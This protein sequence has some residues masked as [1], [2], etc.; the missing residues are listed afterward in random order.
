M[1]IM[2]KIKLFILGMTSIMLFKP[3]VSIAQTFNQPGFLVYSRETSTPNLLYFDLIGSVNNFPAPTGRVEVYQ[4]KIC[5]SH[6]NGSYIDNIKIYDFQANLLNTISV[7]VQLTTCLNFIVLPNLNFALLDNVNDKIY[8]LD[9]NGSLQKTINILDSPSPIYQS[10][11]GVVVENSLI[12]SENE[13]K[14]LLKIDLTNYNVSVFKD[15]SHFSGSLGAI[16]YNNGR[17]YF[18]TADADGRKIYSFIDGQAEELVF[19]LPGTGSYITS[20]V[21]FDDF[22]YATFN[23]EFRILKVNIS[24]SDFTVF[25]SAPEGTFY[26]YDIEGINL[27]SF[28]DPTAASVEA[29]EIAITDATLNGIV[30]ANNISTT[31]TFEYWTEN[32]E[33]SSSPATPSPVTGADNTAVSADITGLDAGTIYYFR[34]K[35]E[36]TQGIAYSDVMTFTTYKSDAIHDFDGNYYNIVEIG[37]QVWMSENLKT[38]KYNDGTSIPLVN[39]P[40]AWTNLT[41]PGYCWYNN[42]QATYGNTYGALYNWYTVNAGKLCP[43]GWHLPT[44]LEWTTL[45]T[46]LDESVAAKKLKESGNA[47][48]LSPHHEGTNETGF[49]ALPGGYRN[50]S[51]GVFWGMGYTGFWESST[52]RPGSTS[53]IYGRNM[54]YESTV[55]ISLSEKRDG[56]SVR[57]IKDV[58]AVPTVST[59]P[60]SI[61][62]AVSAFG[63]GDVIS[64]GGATI[65][66]RG[67]CWSIS[68][69]PTTENSKGLALAG[70]GSYTCNLANLDPNTLYYVRAF[71]RNSAGTGYGTQEYFTTSAELSPISFPDLT[72]GTV[73]DVDDNNY[74][75]IQI[76]SQ[77]WMAENLKTT[78]YNDNTSISIV[79]DDNEWY[80]LTTPAYCWYKNDASNYKAIYGALYNWYVGDAASNGGKNVCPVGWRI[81]SNAEWT[82]LTAYLGGTIVAGGK[83]KEVGTSHWWTP[84]EGATNETGFTAIPGGGRIKDGDFYGHFGHIGEIGFWW[85]KETDVKDRMMRYN[86]G[87]VDLFSAFP[88]QCGFSIRCVKNVSEPIVSTA[89]IGIITSISALSGGDVTSDGGGLISARGVCW[90]TDPTPTVDLVTKTSDG[91]GTGIFSS[92]ITGLT[93]G[94]TYYVRAYAT[95]SAGTSYGDVVTLTTTIQVNDVDD[96]TYNTVKIGDQLW[97]KENLEVVHYRNGDAI[98]NVTDLPAWSNLTNGAYC[99]YDNN[100][101]NGDLYGRLYN[102]Y[103]TVDNRNLCPAGWRI[104]AEFDW[105]V[106]ENYL[107][108]NGYNYDGTSTGNKIAKS[109]ASETGWESSSTTGAVGNTDYSAYRNKSGFTGLPGGF[110]Y[111]VA[112][113]L[114]GF[115][116]IGSGAVWWTSTEVDPAHTT[117]ASIW[118]DWANE[119]R[120]MYGTGDL[121]SS[122]FSVRCIQGEPIVVTNV[123]DQG[124]GSLRKAL[125]DANS[126]PGHDIIIFNIPGKGPFTIKPLTPLPTITDPVVIDGYS[127]PG[128]S[129]G[130][131][132]QLI[133]LDGTS[134]GSESNGLTIDA[135][136]CSVRGLVINKF[137]GTGIQI[138]SGI[139]NWVKA[140]SIFDNGGLGIELFENTNNNQSSPVLEKTVI[141]LGDIYIDGKLTSLP[142]KYFTLDFFASKLADNTGNGE[143]QTYL[144]SGIVTTDADGN[145]LFTGIKFPYQ[146]I[147][148]DVITATAT[149]PDRNTSEFSKAIGGLPDQHLGSNSLDYYVNPT[150]IPNIADEDKIVNAVNDAFATWTGITTAN[151]TFNYVNTTVEQHAHIDGE[152]VVSF[153]DDEYLFGDWVLAITAKTLKLGPTDAET[154]ILDADIIFNPVFVKHKLWNFGIADYIDCAGY[155]DIQSITTHEIGHI[156]GLLHTGVH[157][158]TMWFEM[159]Q[160]IDARTLEQDD[161]SWASYKYPEPGNNFGSISGKITYGYGET[162][163]EPVAGALVLAINSATNDTIHSY[164]DVEGNYIVPGLPSGSYYVYIEPLDG[165]VRG[166]PLSP[167]NISLYI[168]CNTTNFDY[169]G[170]F[171]SGE[172]ETA[173]ESGDNVTSVVVNTG[174]GITGI[175]FITNKDITNPTVVSVTPPDLSKSRDIGIRFSEPMDMATLIKENCYLIKSGEPLPIGGSY[176]D[177][178]DGTNAI[179][180]YP[181]KLLDYSTSYTLYITVGVTDLKGLP[182]LETYIYSFTTGAGDANP[183]TIIGIIPSN[184]ATGVFVNDE[185][186][187]TFSEAMDKLTVQNSLTIN[188][189]I[190]HA[191]S[192]DNENKVLTVTP[193]SNY[194]E[195]GIYNIVVSTG[196]KDMSGNAIQ[197]SVSSNFTVVSAAPPEIDYIEPGDLLKSGVTVKTPVVADFS[198]PINTA[199]VDET[200]F[201]LFKGEENGT[202]VTG[203]FE[204][205]N[206]NSRVVFRPA[207][208]LD[209]NQKYTVVLTTGI[210]DVSLSPQYLQNPKIVS[211]TTATK[212]FVPF[213]KFIDPPSEAV[214]AVVTIGGKGFDPD[215]SR[216]TVTFYNNVAAPVI[217]ATLTSLTVK[218]PVGA[219]SGKVGI[220][221][222]GVQESA[223]SPY[224]FLVIQ[225]Y[226]DPCNEARGSA[227]TGGDSRDVA[228]DFNGTKAYV[229]NSGSNSVS[230]VD[231]KTL[232][233]T[234][235]ISVGEYPLM[236][237]IDPEGKR[238]YVTNH[239]SRTVS[240][241]DLS[242]EKEIKQINVGTNPYGVAVSPDGEH[243]FVANYSSQ[244]I[245]VIDVDPTSGGFDHVTSNIVT[246]TEN[247]KLDID[248]NSSM[249][250]VTGNDGLKIIELI[251][252][253]FGFDYST[254]NANSGTPTRDTKIITEA[255]LAVV[256][257][258]DGRLLFIGVT[259][260]TDT[261]GAVVANSSSPAKA[262]QVQPDFSGVFLYVSNPFDNQVTV[263]KMTYGGNGSDIGSY[264]GFSIKEYW[265][266]PVGISPQGM[267]INRLN[268]ELLVVN[269][270]GQTGSNGSVTAVKICCREKSSSDD[271]VALALYVQGLINSDDI[272]ATDGKMLIKKLNDAV[273]EITRGKTKTAINHLNT[274][275]N[276]VS[277]L[278][279]TGKIT[280]DLGQI[281]IDYA[282]AIIAKLNAGKSDMSETSLTNGEQENLPISITES[283]LGTIYPNPTKEAITINYDI[284]E[285]DKGS[286]KVMIQVYDVIGRLVSNVVNSDQTPGSYT[287]TWNGYSA[288]G[289][290]ASR[291]FYFIRFSAGNVREVKQIML[292]R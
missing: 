157:N 243:V 35:A 9:N 227:Q 137:S 37:S 256:S 229:T 102:V 236:I 241:I 132:T 142:G 118:W 46:Y 258:M 18:C 98:P 207:V 39:E 115:N 217:S 169:P 230:V 201:K 62:T 225:P 25:Y 178:D 47:H 172:N 141:S 257:T 20:I 101:S 279:K 31:V 104:P 146:T 82:T 44:D 7:P 199:T 291:G 11:D 260:G 75:T 290:M 165:D 93:P 206:D 285:S 171:Y 220:K 55:G 81:P 15:F 195:G 6:Y 41:T 237:D 87:E 122:G 85:S 212:T 163:D 32:S 16:D 282:N 61:I 36:S 175:D 116:R 242:T 263:Y 72:Y 274:F 289:E 90:S 106:L 51:T 22:I 238:A 166:R 177:L 120:T 34:V 180:F 145:A 251:K 156:L 155:F 216:N 188:P 103:A 3:E 105:I 100:A 94:T 19:T 130:T 240:V 58:A 189:D 33:I 214:G 2:K 167:R 109:M 64:D 65:I 43:T 126:N 268:N 88:K 114:P 127:Q 71:A 136:N 60:I 139:E 234:N 292:I 266:I 179:L 273:S 148:G 117:A 68:E 149:D 8:F 135:N 190:S 280:Q 200:T 182:L 70:T 215:P 284:A 50:F 288:N 224:D 262:G 221:V 113:G 79:I 4:D 1:D 30:N 54:T 5:I 80:T 99:S 144:G 78:K 232:T 193:L 203:T 181:E 170:E 161:K 277:S 45:T 140:N 250:V 143:G 249:I 95:N 28:P 264:N 187:V 153:S 77:V 253:E 275:I 287:A 186:V 185:I 24:T 40:T 133:Q 192:W 173:E 191:N 261:F 194:T 235:T 13:K 244:D 210:Q 147:Y 248:A 265:K 129:L 196:A 52:E 84:N 271:I 27:S 150:G 267:D 259:K 73:S 202:P 48:W 112:T 67:V 255:G 162:P 131:L 208:D 92:S 57:C 151:F 219:E 245:S 197:N 21:V 226:S 23:Y 12:F 272:S 138:T 247:R 123:S 10:L 17:F 233:T 209:F 154:Q 228:T 42:D 270:F 38:S 134:A 119:T 283:K 164:S 74:R 107:I 168:Y 281:L 254:T 231:L 66:E 239:G 204:F 63:G 49:T 205:L 59:A 121:K 86:D 174:A 184:G 53:G 158:A 198:E 111:P 91:S 14:Q 159:P 246:G 278:K 96:N 211:F 124:T 160:G 76:G 286:E 89:A 110:L 128:A 152:N 223:E 97:F 222:N 218:V 213:I 183:P 83:M 56:L 69:N 108:A 29:T 125:D 176:T 252:T 26:P 276:K 269:E